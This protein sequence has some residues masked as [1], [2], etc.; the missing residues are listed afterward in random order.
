MTGIIRQPAPI[1]NFKFSAERVK[2]L[3]SQGVDSSIFQMLRRPFSLD[4]AL[5]SIT[6]HVPKWLPEDFI[7]PKT[8]VRRQIEACYK[9][10][11]NPMYGSP[12]ICI[13]SMVTDERA[14]F[15]AMTFMDIAISQMKQGAQKG[16][17]MPKWHRILGSFG[18]EL[19]DTK[20]PQNYGM[21]VITNVAPDSTAVKLEKLR[22]ILEIYENVPRIVVVNG[23]DPVSFFAEKVRMPLASAFFL[24]NKGRHNSSNSL[25][26]I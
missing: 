10:M 14:K 12:I 26:E 25:L 2:L 3:R 19:R 5:E 22:D 18:D 4:D 23:S 7:I 20:E 24:N 11:K 21:L 16:K 8:S 9:M 6:P 1:L 13:G 17:R 15:L